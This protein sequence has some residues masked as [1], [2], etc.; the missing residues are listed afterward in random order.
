MNATSVQHRGIFPYL[1]A[2]YCFI[3]LIPA[4]A[5]VTGLFAYFYPQYF[6]LILLLDLWL[7]GYHHVI[8]TFTRIGFDKSSVVEH[9]KLLFP[10]PVLVCIF[11]YSGYQFAGGILIGSIYLYWQWYH[12]TRQSEGIAKT[13]AIKSGSKQFANSPFNRVVFYLV[14]AASFLYLISSGP[15]QFL[16]I[17]IYTFYLPDSFRS[18][19]ICLCLVCIA[20]WLFTAIK[21]YIKNE[22]SGLYLGYSLSHF[23]IYIV[24]YIVINEI[25]YSWLTINIW[26]NAQYIAFVWLYNRK[27]YASGIDPMRRVISYLSQPGRFAQYLLVCLMFSTLT[28]LFLKWAISTLHETAGID[29][30]LTGLVYFAINFHHY[31]VDSK[32]WKLRK[33]EISRNLVSSTG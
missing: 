27:R 31:I 24:S 18:F 30:A 9:W 23:F 16:T 2:D 7:L 26:H 29:L 22:I 3:G 5:V 32:I 14:P 19:L 10:L 6:L 1:S 20:G 25:N 13:Y 8:S 21:A 15:D 12:Y 28:Y 11:V 17:P 33:Q 4:V